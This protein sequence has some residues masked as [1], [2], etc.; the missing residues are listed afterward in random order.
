MEGGKAVGHHVPNGGGE[1]GV[2][3]LHHEPY[4]EYGD[5]EEL[6]HA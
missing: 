3:E 6:G 5:A 2:L 4:G 1:E